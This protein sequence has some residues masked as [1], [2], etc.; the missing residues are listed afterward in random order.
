MLKLLMLLQLWL[1]F[2]SNLSLK[3]GEAM[4]ENPFQ[5]SISPTFYKQLLR[6]QIPRVQKDSQVEQLFALLGSA[7]VK[8][9]GEHNDEIDPGR[10]K[11]IL[12]S[13]SKLRHTNREIFIMKLFDPTVFFQEIS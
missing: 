3:N 4:K 2:N 9:A 11:Y 10:K 1:Y 12:H 6:A 8:A 13:F 7:L 5:L